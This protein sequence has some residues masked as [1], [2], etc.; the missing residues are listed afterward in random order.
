MMLWPLKVHKHM[1]PKVLLARK[2]QLLTDDAALNEEIGLEMRSFCPTTPS[3]HYW[4][5]Y[6]LEKNSSLPDDLKPDLHCKAKCIQ[7][8]EKK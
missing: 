8:L 2:L 6:V 1:K 4:L 7:K 3:Q 5:V